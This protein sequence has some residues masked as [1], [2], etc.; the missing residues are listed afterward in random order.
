M[1]NST[2]PQFIIQNRFTEKYHVGGI[3]EVLKKQM[4]LTMLQEYSADYSE[5]ETTRFFS[6]VDWN[7]SIWPIKDPKT[8]FSKLENFQYKH[9]TNTNTQHQNTTEYTLKIHSNT[10]YT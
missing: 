10:S 9:K 4:Y 2:L 3:K 5:L 8:H 6:E 7:A 1:N